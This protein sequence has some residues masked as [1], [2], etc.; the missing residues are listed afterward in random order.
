M[1]ADPH[2][3]ICVV[4]E[5]QQRG[6]TFPIEVDNHKNKEQLFVLMDT[7]AVR[8][9]INYATFEKLK[10]VKLTNKEVPRVLA[11]DG[12]DLGSIGSVELKL[13]L[14]TQGVTQEF[15]VCRQLRRNII[16]GVDFGKKNCAGVQWTT[17]RTRV[18]SIKGIPA[19]E[20]EETELGLP[21][22][23]AFHVKVPPRHNG[24]FE[25]K[26]HGETEGTYIITPHPQ[27][28]ER[29]P[30]IFQHEIAIF[31][32]EE[33]EPFPLV[34]V[35]NLDQAKTIHIGKGEIVGFARPKTKLVTYIA[36]TNE[37]N[38]EEYVDTS[39]RNWIPKRRRKPL[40]VSEKDEKSTSHYE[41]DE[42]YRNASKK[43]E[44]STFRCG[45]ERLETDDNLQNTGG[46]SNKS[47]NHCLKENEKLMQLDT[48]W[49]DIH[50]VIESDFLISAG[51]IYLKRK[52][53]LQDMTIKDKT[54]RSFE[55]ICNKYEKAFSKNNKD[56]G[57]MHLIEMEIDT[58]NS[59]PLAQ[60]LYTLPLKHYDWVRI[61]IE[62]LEKAGVIERSLSPWASP[63]IIVL[64]KSAPDE[65]PHRRL[66]VDYRKV[67]ALQQEVK[68][69]DKGT[70]CLSLYPLP[71]I[72]EMF[73]KLRGAAVFSTID[74]RS[75]YYH[76][77]LTRESRAKSA[78]VVPM[79]KWQ[80]KHT[81]FGLS[82]APAYFQ[83][84]ID[85]VLMG[86]GEFAM[87][88][89]DDIIIF[90]KNEEDHLHHLE[91]IFSRLQH[92]G[93]KMK[94]EKCAFFKQHIQYLGHLISK[95]GFEPLAEKL[96][97]ICKMP[98]PKSPKEVK[99]FLGLIGYYQKFVPQ[100][101]DISRQLTRLTRHDA[102]FKWS[103]KCEKSFNSL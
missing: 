92:F 69:T 55:D 74:L 57:R 1:S 81:P 62:T 84:L 40:I 27:L 23:A 66:C 88:Y 49:N 52:V 77:E 94:R 89:L 87:G 97:S 79:G 14:G 50:E 68:R 34:A 17:E 101:S 73:S 35:T 48:E 96:E 8:N 25:V 37:I 19:I 103:E 100:F 54:K 102:K 70:G 51:D 98:A 29:N 80:F 11:A 31:S 18:L 2:E 39:P 46:Q 56:I 12:S 4:N 47:S 61:E 90:S 59:V 71:K 3:E 76:I 45:N 75:G 83:L 44:K 91:E 42:S 32:D 22:T 99:Q 38:I 86:C 65:P 28:E 60:S 21:V 6:T 13:I 36:T 82:Q 58:G 16:L 7:G 78:F 85:K 24:V 5:F 95:A 15:I 41:R 93:L 33:V 26:R 10:G 20:V 63:V 43:C 64:K 53:E 72:D 9:S 30:N 67:N